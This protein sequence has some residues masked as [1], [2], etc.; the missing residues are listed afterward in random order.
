MPIEGR[1]Q[2][3][4]REYDAGKV[5]VIESSGGVDG[6]E[7]RGLPVVVLWTRGRRTGSIRKVPLMRVE[8]GGSFAVV[9]SFGGSEKHPVWF[10]NLLEHRVVTVQDGGHIADYRAH[11]ASG[12]ERVVWWALAASIFPDYDRYQG[13][14]E[15]EIP[16]VV[17]DPE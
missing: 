7:H 17:L 14:V 2:P 11:V 4:S 13:L 6:V 3:S 8:R 15:R 12:E 16:L 9:A 10:L 5:A 1:Y